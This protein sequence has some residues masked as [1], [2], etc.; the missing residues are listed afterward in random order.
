MPHKIWVVGEEVL[1]ADFNDYVQ[2]QVIATFPTSSARGT[3]IPSP[4]KG[5]M[6]YIADVNRYE[7]WDGAAWKQPAPTHGVG[8]LWSLHP[9]GTSVVPG[10]IQIHCGQSIVTTNA[11]GE[12][13]ISFPGVFKS[14]VWCA[15]AQCADPGDPWYPSM[16]VLSLVEKHHTLTSATWVATKNTDNVALASVAIRVQFLVIGDRP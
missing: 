6:T 10:P 15:F 3:A 4:L 1:A 14:A 5:M 16:P 7:Y 2:E 8:S 13:S 12:F 11:F 9:D